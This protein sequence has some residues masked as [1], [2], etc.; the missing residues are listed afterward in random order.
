MKNSGS[1]SEKRGVFKKLVKS[2]E[3]AA[4]ARNS[5]E[6]KATG[7]WPVVRKIGKIIYH[8]RKI[9]LAVPVVIAALWLA[10]YNSQHLPAQVGLNLQT[11]GEFANMI[12][13]GTAVMFPLAITGGCLVL[14]FCSRKS[15]YPWLISLFSL[16]VP[17]LLLLT[18]LYPA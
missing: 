16:A 5:R 8:L 3:S 2:Q 12:G 13:R 10:A 14:M 11:T 4:D 6:E 1:S 9:V 18:N 7:F 17:V 15:V